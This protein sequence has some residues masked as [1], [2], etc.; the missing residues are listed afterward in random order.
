[1]LRVRRTTAWA[2]FAAGL[3]SIALTGVLMRFPTGYIKA[4]SSSAG[5]LAGRTDLAELRDAAIRDLAIYVPM[6]TAIGIGMTWLIVAN[7]RRR[8]MLTGLLVIGAVVD[9]AETAL[10]HNTTERLLDG[11]MASALATQTTWT[12]IL[13]A[14]KYVALLAALALLAVTIAGDEPS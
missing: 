1:M 6:Y 2:L 14:I 3:L 9:L 11:A 7:R 8:A 13:S 10:F 4:Q 12:L 5:S